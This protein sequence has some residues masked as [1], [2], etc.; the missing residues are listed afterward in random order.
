MSETS[1]TPELDP[2]ALAEAIEELKAY[3]QRI[4]D[5]TLAMAQKI[6]VSKKAALEQLDKHPEIA[7][8]DEMLAALGQPAASHQ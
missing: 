8:I 1:L 5:D 4:I 3:R 6:K 2:Q 7:Q